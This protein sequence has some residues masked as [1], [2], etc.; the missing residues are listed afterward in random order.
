MKKFYYLLALLPLSLFISCSNDDNFSPTNVTITL[1]GVSLL[2]NTFYTVAGE[3]ITIESLDAKA[4]DGKTTQLGGLT[5]YLNGVPMIGN[6]GDWFD[7]TFSTENLPA[8]NYTLDVT[9]NLLQVDSPII[10]FALSYP[11]KIV[12]NIEDLPSGAP[13]IGTYSQTIRFSKGGE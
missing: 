2:D 13:E 8:G 4:I 5:F 10:G 3:D 7:G 12:E 11:L 1:N 9:G 6:P